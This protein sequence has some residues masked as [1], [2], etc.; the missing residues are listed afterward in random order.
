MGL[1]RGV[2]LLTPA[3]ADTLV[4]LLSQPIAAATLGLVLGVG[5]LFASR[6][7]FAAIGDDPSRSILIA[8]LALIGRLFAATLVLY[9]YS[10]F[11]PEGFPA[12]GVTLAGSFLVMYTVELV[13]YAGLHRYARP[14]A[15]SRDGR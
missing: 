7:S 13:R 5:L 8:G 14:V 3:L 1:L 12:F 6:R 2:I 10:R 4:R 9:L 15:G 11:A